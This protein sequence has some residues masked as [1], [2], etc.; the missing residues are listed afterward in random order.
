MGTKDIAMSMPSVTERGVRI[1][2]RLRVIRTGEQLM[3]GTTAR[4]T[5]PKRLAIDQPESAVLVAA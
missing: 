4:N 1:C 3:P 5:A 2:D